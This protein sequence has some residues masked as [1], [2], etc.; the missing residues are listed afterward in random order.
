MVLK[1]HGQQQTATYLVESLQQAQDAAL[2]L[3]L[4]QASASAVHPQAHEALDADGSSDGARSSHQS[5]S[6]DGGGS[7]SG[8]DGRGGCAEDSSAE[9]GG[10]LSSG[11]GEKEERGEEEKKSKSQLTSLT[12]AG[13]E[14]VAG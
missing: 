3:L 8:A 5:R 4:V 9:H 1:N 6:S 12:A 10:R 13:G 11:E 7:G 14:V 2:D